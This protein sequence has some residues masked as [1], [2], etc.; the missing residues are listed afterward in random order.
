MKS[1]YLG[2]VVEKA[3]KSMVALGMAKDFP[4]K[5]G[6]FR[7]FKETLVSTHNR[8][9]DQ[10]AYLMKRALNLE[11][12]EDT[13]CPCTYDLFKGTT[14]DKV[15][16]CYDQATVDADLMLIEGTRN[17]ATGYTYN[18]SGFA[19]A[20]AVGS[21][22]ILISSSKP[23]ALDRIGMLKRL[24]ENY[25]VNLAGVILNMTDD[26]ATEAFL[27]GKGVNVLGSIPTIRQLK[28]FRVKEIAEALGAEVIVGDEDA[29]YKYVEEVTIGAMTPE[30]AIKYMRRIPRKAVITGGDRS[31][32]Q[33]AAL[34]TDTS[35]LV[36]TGGLYPAKTVVARAYEAEVP[37][38]L[39]RYDT[40][41]TAELIEHLI[42][43][44]DPDDQ[45]EIDTIAKTVKE[46]VDLDK[47]WQDWA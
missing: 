42:A 33:M 22:V 25:K 2:S 29:M 26:P 44:I 40:M 5:V 20:E 16:K 46:H 11:Q 34:S 30:S 27:R 43:R 14:I 39:A 47:I 41:T 19:I 17:I 18:V 23:S 32:I 8:V 1:L 35:C 12:D 3:G 15:T 36:L 4:G 13:L 37:I 10:D 45:S 38:L 9:V 24:M 6:Y 7:P 31:D 21:D 28:Y